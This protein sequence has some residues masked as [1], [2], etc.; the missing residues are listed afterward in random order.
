MSV[1]PTVRLFYQA[2]PVFQMQTQEQFFGFVFKADS[3]RMRFDFFKNKAS[4][5]INHKS[6]LY[7]SASF[8]FVCHC[9]DMLS[10]L[11]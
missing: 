10:L 9:D 3:S 4:N 1:S 11:L 6:G 2:S 8:P 5:Y 7:D